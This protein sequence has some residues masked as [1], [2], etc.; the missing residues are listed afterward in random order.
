MNIGFGVREKVKQHQLMLISQIPAKL[1][2]EVPS[3][4]GN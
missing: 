4:T 2:P 1:S 3:S